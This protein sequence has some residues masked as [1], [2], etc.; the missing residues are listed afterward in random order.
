MKVHL[1]CLV[2]AVVSGCSEQWTRT[3]TVVPAGV[4]RVGMTEGGDGRPFPAWVDVP[5]W[6]D[7]ERR[8]TDAE[9]LTDRPRV[10]FVLKLLSTPKECIR[11]AF[12]HDGWSGHGYSILGDAAAVSL[13]KT[14]SKDIRATMLTAPKLILAQGQSSWVGLFNIATY[15][16]SQSEESSSFLQAENGQ[17]FFAEVTDVSEDRCTFKFSMQSATYHDYASPPDHG[18]WEPPFVPRRWTASGEASLR[19][20]QSYQRVVSADADDLAVVMLLQLAWITYPN[21]EDAPE[22]K[23]QEDAMVPYEHEATLATG[24]NPPDRRGGERERGLP[25]RRGR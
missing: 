15:R 20:G 21:A 13:E 4:S 19:V 1:A 17:V 14:M 2:L 5:E 10:T 6:L 9:V 25:R 8:T 24:L 7:T 3:V 12:G 23:A 22:P 16:I 11:E 18:T